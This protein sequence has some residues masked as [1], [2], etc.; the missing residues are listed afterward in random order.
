MSRSSIIIIYSNR[1]M[2]NGYEE[3]T[4]ECLDSRAFL[5]DRNE[6]LKVLSEKFCQSWMLDQGDMSHPLH[7]SF[8]IVP[9]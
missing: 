8:Y 5:L 2:Y 6:I 3:L 1:K 9:S 4:F 7:T